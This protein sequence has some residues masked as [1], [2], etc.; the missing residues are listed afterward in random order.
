VCSCP[1]PEAFEDH[2]FG[3]HAPS[4][5]GA[6]PSRGQGHPDDLGTTA[7]VVGAPA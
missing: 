1:P 7:D 4:G 3:A 5:N 2:D 6:V